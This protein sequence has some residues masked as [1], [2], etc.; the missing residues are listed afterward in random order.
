MI[1]KMQRSN[2][3][4][5]SEARESALVESQYSGHYINELVI[6]AARKRD[7]SLKTTWSRRL[8]ILGVALISGTAVVPSNAADGRQSLSLLLFSRGFEF[9]VALDQGARREAAKQGVNL[10]VLDGQSSATVQTGQVD[11]LI[12]KKVSALM[13]SPANSQEIV[14]AV[15]RANE[16]NIPV[17][18]VDGIVA[19][20]A[21]VVTYVG[22]DNAAGAKVAADYLVQHHAKKILELQGA[23]GEYHAQLRH[24]GLM[25]G[26]A[27]DPGVKVISRPA[28]WLAEKAQSMTADALTA[29]PTIDAIFSHN[30]E[31]IRGIVAGLKQ[32]GKFKKPGE[33]GHIMIVGI[34]GTPLALQRIRNGEE[35]ATV[36]QDPFVMG[37]LAVD[38]AVNS[39]AGKES[40]PQQLLPPTLVTKDNVD[41]PTLWGNEF[42][43]GT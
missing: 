6:R 3:S 10:T 28:E 1:S 14:P 35:D 12:T 22:F 13:V 9:M 7:R 15:R 33:E 41:T 27:A 17:V 29:D 26:L 4:L 16:A 2:R 20:G 5:G 25:E 23:Q 43:P 37:A 24:K 31:M 30:D 34:D 39:L 8:T 36:Q 21:K 42:K 38:S 19:P 40:P 11:D 32:I 18:A